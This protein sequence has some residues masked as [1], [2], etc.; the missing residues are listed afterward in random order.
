[1]SAP[2]IPH[3]PDVE[4]VAGGDAMTE[5]DIPEIIVEGAEGLPEFVS[6]GVVG[7]GVAG[8]LL[9]RAVDDATGDR[10]SGALEDEIED[11]LR[12][13]GITTDVKLDPVLEGLPSCGLPDY[14]SQ[15]SSLPDDASQNSS[16]LPDD[17]SQNSSQLPDDGSQNSSQLPD[18]GSQNSSQ[19][20]DDGS[21]NSSQLPDD[22]SQ[23]SSQLPDDASQNSSQLPDDA[24]QNSSQLPDD[25]SGGH[26]DFFD[27][28]EG[29]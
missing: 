16:Q 11:R 9:G 29:I 27:A 21:Q 6:P 2:D 14:G 12:P 15:T 20:P 22:G 17:G 3:I 25:D 13:F 10:I 19:L 24:S 5:A 28:A 26:F 7:A 8:Y 4:E 1:V 23:N 18:D